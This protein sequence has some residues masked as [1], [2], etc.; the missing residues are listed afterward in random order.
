MNES[1][2]VL[3]TAAELAAHLRVSKATIYQRARRHELPCFRIGDRIVFKLADV[4][5]SI[6]QP[7]GAVR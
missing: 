3:L 2:E 4:L 7:A 1:N 6:Q 5:A